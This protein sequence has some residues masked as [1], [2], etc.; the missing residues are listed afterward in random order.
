VVQMVE[1]DDQLVEHA[2]VMLDLAG[3]LPR[4]FSIRPATVMRRSISISRFE[5]ENSDGFP[6]WRLA[7]LRCVSYMMPDF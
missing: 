4:R 7:V 3:D 1:I 2:L 6:L 5:P